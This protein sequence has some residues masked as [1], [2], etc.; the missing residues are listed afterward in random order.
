M[1]STIKRLAILRTRHGRRW[2]AGG[3]ILLSLVAIFAYQTRPTTT[4]PNERWLHVQPQALENHLGLVGRIEAA[5]QTTL[6]APFEGRVL[7]IAVTEG[8]RVERDQ[9]LLTLDTTQ[10]DIQLREALA[11]QLKAQRIV[12]DMQSWPQSEEV[13]RSR[14]AMTNAQLGLSDTRSKLAD[15]RRLF[16]RGI[17]ARMEVDALE[18]QARTQ[19]LD[20]TASQAELS[21]ALDKGK[22]EN[23]QIAEMELTNTQARYQALQ[24]LHA[25]RQLHAPFAGIVLRP[26]KQEGGSAPMAQQGMRA[27]LDMPLFELASLERIKAVTRVEEA[28][29]YQLSEGMQVQITGDGFDG[30]TLQGRIAAIGVQGIASEMYG[31]G[32]MYEVVVAI[33]PLMPAQQQR[34]RLGMSARLAILTYRAESGL[35]VPAEALHRDDEGNAIVKYRVEMNQAPRMLTVTTGRA[36]PQGVEVFGLAPGYVELPLSAP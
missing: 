9:H 27:T 2:L 12:Q 8:Q 25:Q 14:R 28:D 36:V 33:D 21:A 35:A 31:G 18:Q 4:T 16:E 29:L 3:L 6:A 1:T 24:A 5:M 23:R 20:L 11:A 22:G 15:T 32:T 7:A 10:L 34:V 13:A 17:V 26:R 30:I 19:Q